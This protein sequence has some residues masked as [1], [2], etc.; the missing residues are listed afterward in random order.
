MHLS[1][2]AMIFVVS[3]YVIVS[4]SP[5]LMS[6]LCGQD[7]AG[8]LVE[9]WPYPAA[10]SNFTYAC[11]WQHRLQYDLGCCSQSL[12]ISPDAMRRRVPSS[13]SES[14]PFSEPDIGPSPTAV[15]DSDDASGAA[16]V[17]DPW[18]WQA[19]VDEE[20]AYLAAQ[21]QRRQIVQPGQAAGSSAQLAT[22]PVAAH[23]AAAPPDP[24]N[25]PR[26]CGR[27]R[28]SIRIDSGT[29]GARALHEA[30]PAY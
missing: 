6:A 2:L 9:T 14:E 19:L 16:T 25:A 4:S 1:P 10:V 22:T 5:Y 15:P 8:R 21:E 3:L 28:R 29:Y 18:D 24:D 12:V 30:C 27:K 17:I 7:F 13:P 26:P 20:N 23:A 11:E